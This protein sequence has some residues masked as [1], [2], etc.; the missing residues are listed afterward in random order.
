MSSRMTWRKLDPSI[1]INISGEVNY[2]LSKMDSESSSQ[3]RVDPWLHIIIY[4]KTTSNFGIVSLLVVNMISLA[5]P[6]PIGNSF[7]IRSRRFWFY[8]FFWKLCIN[9]VE[10]DILHSS[11]SIDLPLLLILSNQ[12]ALASCYFTNMEIFI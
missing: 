7:W 10:F 11:S 12:Y 9:I 3:V 5:L 4:N 2:N 6:L 1:R 8:P